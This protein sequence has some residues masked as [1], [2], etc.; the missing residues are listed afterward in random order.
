VRH[1]A[2]LHISLLSISHHG[3]LR[4]HE[5]P[6]SYATLA[7][8]LCAE[9]K[10][11]LQAMYARGT[12]FTPLVPTSALPYLAFILLTTTFGLTFYF[13]TCVSLVSYHPSI[14]VLIID[15]PHSPDCQ[16]VGFRH[17]SWALPQSRVCWVA[18]ASSPSSAAWGFTCE[19]YREGKMMYVCTRD[20]FAG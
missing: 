1:V 12:P 20:I 6:L 16:R 3:R 4:F 5:R 8:G 14:L 18:S 11:L 17:A 7:F 2:A 15:P 19:V 10:L 13:S 9:I